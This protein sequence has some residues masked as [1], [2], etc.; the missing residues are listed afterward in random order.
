MLFVFPEIQSFTEGA[1]IWQA[2]AR[3]ACVTL[4]GPAIARLSRS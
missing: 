4:G 3:A 2:R 1:V